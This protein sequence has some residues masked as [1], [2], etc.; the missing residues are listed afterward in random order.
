MDSTTV[1]SI[2]AAVISTFVFIWQIY[3]FY[4]DR[5]GKIRI[6]VIDVGFPLAEYYDESDTSH[7]VISLITNVGSQTRHI[8]SPYFNV[9]PAMVLKEHSQ[10]LLN[11]SYNGPIELQPGQEV[12]YRIPM[13]LLVKYRKA[14]VRKIRVEVG[15]THKKLYKSKWVRL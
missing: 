13:P 6:K 2:Y 8:K 12:T 9:R 3:E 7:E 14:G 15:D 5:K 4:H 11:G 1:I 10:I